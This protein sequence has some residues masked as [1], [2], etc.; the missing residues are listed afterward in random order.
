MKILQ[1]LRRKGQ[2]IFST[3]F[4]YKGIVCSDDN[5]PDQLARRRVYFLGEP[6]WRVAFLCPCGCKEMVELCLLE[7][8]KPHWTAALDSDARVSLSP[9]VWKNAGCRSHYF[10]R[11]GQIIWV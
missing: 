7:Q 5:L 3:W 6:A 4:P 11:R 8:H 9:S 10:M 2:N 1:S